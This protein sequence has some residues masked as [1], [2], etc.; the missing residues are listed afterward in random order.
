MEEIENILKELNINMSAIYK[1]GEGI[2]QTKINLSNLPV[3]V[4]DVKIIKNSEI[5]E[6]KYR[7]GYMCI[8]EL[9]KLKMKTVYDISCL[10]EIV[11]KG[12]YGQPGG[13]LVKKIPNPKISEVFSCLMIDS[14]VINY[15]SFESW[16][17]NFGYN[18]DSRND[19]K[20]Y[21]ECLSS[22]L[23][24]RSMTGDLY[25]KKLMDLSYAL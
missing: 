19:Y 14:D 7:C 21:S 12:L 1:K 5:L 15:S 20:I 13:P 18:S 10:T 17:D 22:A 9:R 2:P 6:T 16:C 23:K 25:F 11:E 24:I 8:P 3:F 4:W